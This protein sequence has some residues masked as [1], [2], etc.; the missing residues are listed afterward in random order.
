M[1]LQCKWGM[2]SAPASPAIPAQHLL[3]EQPHG[4]FKDTFSIILGSRMLGM[5]LAG[6]M[7]PIPLLPGL[8][9]MAYAL[10]VSAS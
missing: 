4:V 1:L 9:A 8:A 3:Q 2:A 10:H 6:I 7:F 5:L